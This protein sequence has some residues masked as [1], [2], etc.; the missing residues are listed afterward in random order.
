MVTD[1]RER[2]IMFFKKKSAGRAVLCVAVF[3]A[4]WLMGGC[5]NTGVHDKEVYKPDLPAAVEEA[6]IYVEP[7]EGLS[8]D[9]IK[10]ID[11]SSLIAEE[12][13]GVVYYNEN[14]DEEDL[15]KILADAGI[16]YVRV[17]VWNDPYDKDGNGYGGGN[18]DVDKAAEIGKR[19]AE[20]GMKLAVDFHYSDFWADPAK[21]QAP[22]EWAHMTFEDKKQAIYDFTAE[23]LA[24]ISEAGADIGIVQI[25]NEINNGMSGETED[26]RIAGLLCQASAAVR[27][28]SE[29]IEIAV[30]YTNVEDSK[31]ILSKAKMLEDVGVDYDIFGVSYYMFWHG[32]TDNLIGTLKQ[33]ESDYGK[34]TCIMETSYAYTLEDGDAFSN[35]V[36]ETDLLPEYGATVQSQ[37][38]CIRDVMAAANEAGALGVFYWEGAWIPVGAEYEANSEL[39]EKYGSGWA[40]SYAAKYDPDD[41]GQYYGGCSWD[42]QALFDFSGHPLASLNVFK[43]VNYGTTCEQKVDFIK[44][45]SLKLN[46]GE[47]L[48]MPETIEAVM[49]DR[50]ENDGVAVTWDETQV[51]A[52]DTDVMGEYTVNGELDDGTKVVCDIT[53]AKLNYMR[54]PGFEENNTTM[55]NVEYGGNANP[56]DFQKKAADALTGEMSFHFYDTDNMEFNVEQT[57]TGLE[58]G[59]YTLSTNIQGGDV[60]ADAEIYLYAEAD[61][62]IYKS[63]TVVLDGWANWK[64][65]EIKD[66]E[67]S[68]DGDIT[69]GV[70]VKCK[71]KGWGTMDDFFLYKQ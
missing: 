46:V 62:R 14:G 65:P 55:W 42:N 61:G 5:A 43:Y 25:G 63:E 56:A 41:A 57:V 66:I 70:Y 53:V 21:Q 71:A 4:A 64:T 34:K 30:H 49:N 68:S 29:D 7:I 11:I 67:L 69:A 24:A 10:G 23:S 20:Y 27:E 9:F 35:S 54:N 48:V 26:D 60:G 39:W 59:S 32:T 17:R 40:S 33:I 16:N 15:L 19:A 36:G 52:I 50:A 13:S 45:C 18:C 22:K 31:N 44:D 2:M 58:A 8:D 12:E 1:I 51:K 28:F 6:D 3:M 47:E 37:A 38:T